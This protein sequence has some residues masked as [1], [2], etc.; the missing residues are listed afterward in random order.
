MISLIA[1]A[2]VE[3]SVEDRAI[4]E[5]APLRWLPPKSLAGAQSAQGAYT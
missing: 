2:L 1:G 3:R 4:L 5:V